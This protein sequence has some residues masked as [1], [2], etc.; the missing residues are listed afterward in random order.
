MLNLSDPPFVSSCRT[1]DFFIFQPT[2]I[3]NSILPKLIRK[4]EVSLSQKLKIVSPNSLNPDSGPKDNE[5]N[6]PSSQVA[7]KMSATALRRLI[8]RSSQKTKAGTVEDGA[9]QLSFFQLD[10]PTLSAIR[11]Y[12]KDADLNNMTPMQAYDFLREMKGELGL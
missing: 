9:G 3:T 12:L 2:K 7:Q 5:H 11:D 4:L 6:A 8:L 1:V 10:D